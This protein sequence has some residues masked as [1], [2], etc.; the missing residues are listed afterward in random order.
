MF[1]FFCLD[2][3]LQFWRPLLWNVYKENSIF[4]WTQKTRRP[5]PQQA[6]RGVP[7]SGAVVYRRISSKEAKYGNS[8][9][10]IGNFYN[11]NLEFVRKVVL[12]WHYVIVFF[13]LET[14]LRF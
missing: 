1:F 3:C 2:W 13:N 7:G 6:R 9:K 5:C 14:F 12:E 11:D 8:Y 10:E 4:L